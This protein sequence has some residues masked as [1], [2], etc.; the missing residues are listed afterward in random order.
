[1]GYSFILKM[2]YNTIFKKDGNMT[3]KNSFKD[4]NM[5]KKTLLNPTEKLF[6]VV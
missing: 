5:T 2:H 4:G 3:K 1:M 6:E